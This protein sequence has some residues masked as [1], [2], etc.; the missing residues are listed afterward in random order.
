MVS[1]SRLFGMSCSCISHFPL[2][3]KAAGLIF[4]GVTTIPETTWGL[5]VA[6][7]SPHAKAISYAISNLLD[8]GFI[9]ERQRFY[10][11]QHYG[12]SSILSNPG[13]M[14]SRKNILVIATSRCGS[15]WGRGGM[16]QQRLESPITV[17]APNTTLG[18]C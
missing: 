6:T 11:K 18:I 10:E 14:F 2:P 15:N 13:S 3:C 7:G 8:S 1:S 4:L 16:I 12:C 9:E 17:G 5:P